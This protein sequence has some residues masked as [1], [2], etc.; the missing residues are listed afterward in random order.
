MTTYLAEDNVMF[1]QQLAKNTGVPMGKLIDQALDGFFSEIAGREPAT[2]H[3]DVEHLK[4]AG[5][6]IEKKVG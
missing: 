6:R 5:R 3:A 4:R 1:L 2:T